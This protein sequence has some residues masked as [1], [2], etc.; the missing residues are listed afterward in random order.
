MEGKLPSYTTQ[1]KGLR[2]HG[3]ECPEYEG[4]VYIYPVLSI[5]WVS[6]EGARTKTHRSIGAM[7]VRKAVVVVG[8]EDTITIRVV[9]EC[10]L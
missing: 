9:C 2:S 6:L 7:M 8:M 3:A 5:H 10:A 4:Q 1:G